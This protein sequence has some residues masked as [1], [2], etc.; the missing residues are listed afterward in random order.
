[1][2]FREVQRMEVIEVIRRWQ[3]GESG[4][5]IA[6]S[7]GLARNTVEKYLRA[8]R[9]AGLSEDGEPWRE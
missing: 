6:R 9:A 2:A 7:T 1:M 3:A 5:A 4:R 8:A